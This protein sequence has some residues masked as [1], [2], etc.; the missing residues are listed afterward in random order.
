MDRTTKQ[1]ISKKT[2]GLNN[3]INQLDV[4]DI[5]RTLYPTTEYTV[6]SGAHR[7]F[8]RIDPILGQKL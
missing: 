2:E 6:F 8:S 1:K 5:C 3:T 7:T 4:T